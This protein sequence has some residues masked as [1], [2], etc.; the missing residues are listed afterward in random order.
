MT[1]RG[2]ILV[3]AS[4]LGAALT[5]WLALLG[6]MRGMTGPDSGPSWLVAFWVTMTAAMMLPA[7]V[8]TVLLVS[9]VRGKLDTLAFVTAYVVAW[10]A[11]GIVAYGGYEALGAVTSWHVAGRWAAGAALVAAGLYQLTPL[12]DACLRHCRSPL[13]LIARGGRG[14]LGATTTGLRH[15]GFCMGCCAGLMLALFALGAM[16]LFWMGAVATVILVEKTF[17]VGEWLARAAGLALL[18]VGVWT[19]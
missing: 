9:S 1:M 15:A 8:P 7:A 13:S 18:V 11:A 10:S 14:P 5:G 2:R 12:M 6:Q 3:G 19:L 16:S 4:V 17:P